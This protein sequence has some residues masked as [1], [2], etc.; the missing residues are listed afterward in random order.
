[1]FTVSIPL[2][3]T[4]TTPEEPL[5]LVA[6]DEARIRE[7]VCRALE[8]RCTEACSNAEEV[9]EN[10]DRASLLL[11]D[12]R[13]G[14]DDG[15]ELLAELR[16]KRPELPIV[17]MTAFASIESAV[18][19]MKRGATDYLTKPFGSL[20]ELRLVVDRALAVDRLRR[21]NDDLRRLLADQ[22][23][24]EEMIGGSETMKR[25]Y[26][27][28]S[29]IAPGDGTVLITGESGTGKELVARAIH[30]RSPRVSRPFIEINCAAIPETLLE[31]ELFGHEKGAF[32]GAVR[33]RR[34]ILESAAGGTVFLDEIGELTPAL[35]AK[36]LRAIEEKRF[37][38]LGSSTAI[39]VDVR[40]VAATNRNLAEGIQ[41]GTFREDLFYRLAVLQIEVPPLRE[42][43]GDVVRLLKEM[44]PATPID[45]LALDALLAHPWPGNIREL[46]NFT[47]RVR[48]LGLARVTLA[49]L[50]PGFRESRASAG[51]NEGSLPDRVGS[52]EKDLI[53][54]ALKDSKGSRTAAARRLGVTRQALQYKLEKY[55]IGTD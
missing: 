12:L 40:I 47:E 53:L 42:R 51:K 49:D 32:T 20:D 21:E 30:R 35:Q 55:G 7:L 3:T 26:E 14:A 41:H 1:M 54:E 9:R 11:L 29:R 36:L 50:P 31:S 16:E 19:A 2:D 34:G 27:L 17:I 28:I 4:M 22:D 33:L 38:R 15:M 52:F 48:G 8:G 43:E 6:D 45:A 23:R 37:H 46:K 18:E 10:A 24:F 39:R 13:L 5:I 44:L 25:L